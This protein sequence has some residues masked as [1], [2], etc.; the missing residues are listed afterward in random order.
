MGRVLQSTGIMTKRERIPYELYDSSLSIDENAVRLN[1]KPSTIRK[2]IKKSGIDRK[3]DVQ[4]VRWKKVH[5]FSKKH[6]DYT[7]EQKKKELNL[8]INT[9]RKYEKMSED[10]L[11]DAIRNT[12][13]V[14]Q[15][16]IKNIN[17][18]KT[19]SS[20][21]TEILRWIVALYNNNQTFEADLTASK[22][23]FYKQLSSPPYLY[24]KYPQLPQVKDLKETDSLSDKSFASI[25][26]DLPFIVS[27]LRTDNIIKDRFSFFTSVNEAYETNIEMLNRAYRLLKDNGILV[28]KTMDFAYSGQQYWI[29]DFVLRKAEELGLK[30]LDKFILTSNLRLFTK[31]RKQRIARKYHSY[32]FVFRKE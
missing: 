5:D 17:A 21:Q 14:S 3:Y 15:F 13:K 6:P 23:I 27:D 2:Y 22:L 19:I 7:Y 26:Y 25:I 24:D 12:A 16:D 8:S 1:C 29:S 31:T 4:Y 28:I 9:I 20:N 18:V 30:L 10:E 11:D 32:F